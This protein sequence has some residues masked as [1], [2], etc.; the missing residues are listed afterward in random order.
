MDLTALLDSSNL[1]ALDDDTTL[2]E[3]LVLAD[4]K[5]YVAHG[6]DPLCFKTSRMFDLS[7]VPENYYEATH[8][9]DAQV[10][11]GAMDCE[12]ESLKEQHVF[13][14]AELLPGCKAI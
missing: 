11:K 10:W 12:V 1:T 3:Q 14:P 5:A 7:K 8:R 2:I 6:P 13:E 4:Y 9:S